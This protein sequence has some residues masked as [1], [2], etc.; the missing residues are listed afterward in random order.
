MSHQ[1][2]NVSFQDRY[3]LLACNKMM[4]NA[5]KVLLGDIF[6]KNCASLLLKFVMKIE[7]S[8]ANKIP[9]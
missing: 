2:L 8:I 7:T 9:W 5:H 3:I 6:I 4:E 1:D